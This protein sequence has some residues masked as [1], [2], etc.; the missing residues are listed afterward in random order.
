M[1]TN[2][3]AG[4]CSVSG[5]PKTAVTSASELKRLRARVARLEAECAQHRHYEKQRSVFARLAQRLAATTSEQDLMEVVCEATEALFEWEFT[6]LAHRP[7]G[8]KDVRIIA[9]YDTVNG[10]KRRFPGNTQPLSALGFSKPIL[11]VLRGKPVLINREHPK[12]GPVMYI[13]GSKR[14]SASML[15]APVRCDRRVI[16]FVTVH[17]Y[18][19]HRYDRKDL[20]LLQQVADIVAPA[21]E[22]VYAEQALRAAHEKLEERVRQRT[23]ELKEINRQLR[24]ETCERK[25]ALE[26]VQESE[27]RFRAV[28][29]NSLSGVYIYDG[30]QF[31]YIN[32]A[33]A[34]IFGYTPD[35]ILSLDPLCLIHP[36]DR[37]AV[38]EQIRRRLHGAVERAQYRCRGLRKDGAV[39]NIEV[40][41]R[42]SEYRGK[43]V[44]FGNLLDITGR[45]RAEKAR[46]KSERLLRKLTV[47]MDR[48]LESERARIARE[49]H[50][51]L[52]QI[53]T[54]LNMNLAWLDKRTK[55]SPSAVQ[56]R[57][58]ESI[59]YVSQ[60]TTIIRS[61]CK[62]LHP[63]VLDHHG[64]VEAIRS[65][66]AD[67]E[68]Y[69][70][71]R[72]NL[73]IRPDN[74]EVP[75][76]IAIPAFRI[77]QEA[78]TNVARHSQ[79]TRCGVSVQIEDKT[80]VIVIRD[81]GVGA[82]ASRLSGTHSLG[83]MGMQE[84]AAAVGGTFQIETTA[85]GGIRATARLPLSPSCKTGPKATKRV[86]GRSSDRLPA[87][88]ASDN[89]G[90]ARR[91]SRG[92]ASG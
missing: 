61:L 22:R 18:Q 56:A 17:S 9:Y 91:A 69:S 31:L 12:A 85:R 71:I 55:S 32:S 4:R 40:L 3:A 92:N 27:A 45:I 73:S 42:V 88:I 35:E 46:R 64:L 25:A 47:E 60:M 16:G 81:N 84:R 65:Q 23:A 52:G 30:K 76:A 57:V 83:I 41:G 90:R 58:N 77:V 14:R 2:L 87:R 50:D 10:K 19:P 66:V 80:L 74:L 7:P 8:Q 43:R 62:S 15:Y 37:S 54:A 24:R 78:L 6:F 70:G 34:E 51:D 79:A 86:A 39:I 29:E 44:I 89:N 75:Q 68:Q 49:L 59:G 82:P 21:L 53:L 72:C 13:V 33:F 5:K 26:A 1:E 67:F 28:T 20:D 36:A 38:A 63:V 11:Q 48:R